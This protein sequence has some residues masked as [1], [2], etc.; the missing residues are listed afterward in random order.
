[1]KERSIAHKVLKNLQSNC[2]IAR[3]RKLTD[4]NGEGIRC[5]QSKTED[6]FASFS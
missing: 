6:T 1:M 5:S 2:L 4:V 3:E